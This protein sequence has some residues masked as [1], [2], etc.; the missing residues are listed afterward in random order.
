MTLLQGWRVVKAEGGKRLK[1]VLLESTREGAQRSV[2]CDFLC[3]APNPEPVTAL[4]SQADARLTYD[5]V[6][7]AMVPSQLPDSVYA[8]G[9]V[10][11]F[12]D[13]EVHLLQGRIAG[14]KAAA[15]SGAGGA[16]DNLDGLT[17]QLALAESV[18]RGEVSSSPFRS[19]VGKRFGR[20]KRFVCL[21]EDVTEK[22]VRQ[23]ID[24]GF[25][26]VQSLKRYSTVSMG[27]C[28]G[29]MCHKSYTYLISEATGRGLDAVGGT[30]PR[31]PF[32]PTPL[33]AIAG[34]GH[35]P[36][37]MTPMH[38]AHVRAGGKMAEVGQWKRPHSYGD[39]IE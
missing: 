4:L 27:P 35:M 28:Q 9:D 13:V 30:T 7:G 36:F 22:D 10:T 12:Q 16:G 38:Y 31:P 32:H 34:P 8:A 3:L 20:T 15:A 25:A 37:R 39:P 2:D 24:E 23:A 5:E 17:G 26:D 14:L 29:K 6:L 33:G 21:C 19:T 1:S 11:G 18:H